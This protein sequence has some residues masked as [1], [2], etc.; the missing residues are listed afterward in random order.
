MGLKLP[1]PPGLTQLTIRRVNNGTLF[2]HHFGPKE[3]HFGF[4][5]PKKAALHLERTLR[6]Q[7]QAAE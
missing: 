2:T 6:G 3:L 1:K 7:W 5:S 4:R